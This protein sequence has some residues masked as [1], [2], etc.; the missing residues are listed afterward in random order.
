MI[1]KILSIN[2]DEIIADQNVNLIEQHDDAIEI[3]NKYH[4]LI[5]V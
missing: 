5:F 3:L 1:E 4:Q 2:P